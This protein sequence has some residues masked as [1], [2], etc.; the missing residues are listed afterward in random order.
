MTITTAPLSAG[1]KPAKAEKHVHII[2]LVPDAALAA[3]MPKT[4]TDSQLTEASRHVGKPAKTD[5]VV[6]DHQPWHVVNGELKAHPKVHVDYPETVLEISFGR[7]ERAV[8]WS[9][10]P[11]TITSVRRSDHHPAV[12]GSPVHPFDGPP[13]P[14]DA[15]PEMDLAGQPIWAVRA[16]PIVKESIGQMYKINFFM[17]EN[18]D[19][20]MSCGN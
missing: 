5:I 14:Y 18:I 10:Q 3:A 16:N 7:K 8:W 12:H 2:K 13:P 11:F 19:P 6:F 15:R 4:P 9:E 20:D 1:L 17:G